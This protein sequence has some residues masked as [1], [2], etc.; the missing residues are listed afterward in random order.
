MSQLIKVRKKQRST[1]TTKYQTQQIMEY[2]FSMGQ[3]H[4]K[5]AFISATISYA[6]DLPMPSVRR[7][8]NDMYKR[9]FITKFNQNQNTIQGMYLPPTEEQMTDFVRWYMR[10]KAYVRN[11]GTTKHD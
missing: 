9:E 2:V 7:I 3:Q 8:L 4:E 1:P 10:K 5:I 11:S 6:L